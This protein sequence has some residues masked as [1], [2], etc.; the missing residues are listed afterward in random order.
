MT[1][2]RPSRTL[3]IA[4]MLTILLLG[5]MTAWAAWIA[6]HYKNLI[7][8]KLPG[9]IADATDSVYHV[10]LKDISINI[11]TRRVTLSGIRLWPDT[12]RVNE[13]KALRQ[14]PSITTVEFEVPKA[15]IKGV[16]WGNIITKNEVD[17]KQV[18]LWQANGTITHIPVLADS[19]ARNQ[20]D[21]PKQTKRKTGVIKQFSVG[22]ID[23]MQSNIKFRSRG[24][25]DDSSLWEMNNCNVTLNDWL[26]KANQ[27]NDTSRFLFAKKGRVQMD[28][29]VY[30]TSGTIY[31]ISTSDIDF[32]TESHRLE[33][34]NFAITSSVTEH[35]FYKIYRYQKE[36]YRVR[37][38]SVIFEEL[39]WTKWINDHQLIAERML[40]KRPSMLIFLSRIPEQSGLNRAG[41][42]PHQLLHKMSLKVAINQ[43]KISDGEVKYAEVSNVTKKEGDVNYDA[44][45]G[46]IY[47][48]TNIDSLVEKHKICTVALAG[49]LYKNSDIRATFKL[50]LPD[51]N[52]YFTMDG[53][54][55]SLDAAQINNAAE[56]LAVVKIKSFHV[57]NMKMHV[58]GNQYKSTG[59]FTIPYSDFK[60]ELQ[61]AKKTGDTPRIKDKHVTSFLANNFV[62]Y[63]DNPMPGEHL[64]SASASVKRDP[65]KSFFGLIWKN[66][67]SGLE[68]TVVKSK[69]LEN[70]AK[71][72]GKKE[73]IFQ[74]LFGKK[75]K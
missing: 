1:K 11:I 43:I 63:S 73:G 2:K 53:T 32:K 19:V 46:T 61:A 45:N 12:A 52:G 5:G 48:V 26:I 22:E 60:L 70:V 50:S 15:E 18:V 41:K 44:I 33:I 34:K 58:E 66:I 3:T 6:N 75:N 38:P 56:A 59:Q 40:L 65:Y 51:T 20:V 13:L 31:N 37:F 57:S 47:N 35:E 36:I 4:L 54:L 64:R 9:W 39:N 23:L 67:Y 25:D 42:F 30:K 28:S 7:R 27:N 14:K 71:K 72:H 24:K 17:C 68:Q 21:S 69:T 8:D 10:S 74:R 29:L 62:F 49:K 55:K 16:N